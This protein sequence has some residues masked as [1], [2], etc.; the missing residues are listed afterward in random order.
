MMRGES[1]MGHPGYD[2]CFTFLAVSPLVTSF[3]KT[4]PSGHGH[5]DHDFPGNENLGIG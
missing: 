2:H 3:P 5:Q 1:W 4:I